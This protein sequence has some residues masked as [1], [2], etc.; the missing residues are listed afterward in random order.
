MSDADASTR[1]A[2]LA[3]L[4]HYLTFVTAGTIAFITDVSVFM[5]LHDL[6]RVWVQ[7]AR[8]LSI[9]V[10]MVVSWLI[11]RTWTFAVQQ[12]PSLLEFLRFAAMGWVSS[13]CNYAV[14]LAIVLLAPD[15]PY[16]LDIGISSVVAMAV[17]YLG[18]SRAVFRA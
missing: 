1:V 16:W 6:M 2:T 4:K 10:A 3:R 18:M 13:A 8:F 12:S 11:N 7:P 9:S 17:S 15:L 5:L 14:F